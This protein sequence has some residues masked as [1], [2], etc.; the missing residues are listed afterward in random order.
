MNQNSLVTF[1]G[2]LMLMVSIATTAKEGGFTVI[3]PGHGP[4]S[5]KG[6]LMACTNMLRTISSHIRKMIAEQSS[7]EQILAAEPTKDFDDE[8]GNGAIKN[9][10]FVE[11]LYKDMTIQ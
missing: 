6:G 10:A 9:A 11:M 5:D 3:I 1:T 2:I 7:L 4:V 8:Y